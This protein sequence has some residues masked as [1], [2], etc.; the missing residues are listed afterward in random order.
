MLVSVGVMMMVG[1]W[2]S[3]TRGWSL[4]RS[5]MRWQ[6]RGQLSRRFGHENVFPVHSTPASGSLVQDMPVVLLSGVANGKLGNIADR[7][8]QISRSHIAEIQWVEWCSDAQ[9][10]SRRVCEDPVAFMTSH[11][12]R[13]VALISDLA[14]RD[15]EW[16]SS[17]L[18]SPDTFL[19]VSQL[20]GCTGDLLED[21]LKGNLA[22]YA[23]REQNYA[24]FMQWLKEHHRNFINQFQDECRSLNEFRPVPE[25]FTEAGYNDDLH[26][27]FGSHLQALAP[28]WSMPP[29]PPDRQELPLILQDIDGCIK[30]SYCTTEPKYNQFVVDRLN[31]WSRKRTAEVRWMTYWGRRAATV[32]GPTVGLDTFEHGRDVYVED[33]D[34]EV[35][36]FRW[37]ERNPERKI[38]WVDDEIHHYLRSFGSKKNSNLPLVDR[39]MQH[40]NLLMVQP[41]CMKGLTTEELKTI[42]IFL[43]G[44]MKAEEVLAQNMRIV[45]NEKK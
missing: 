1:L 35:Q 26:K 14:S 12:K 2:V 18:Q 16:L 38:V 20:H 28:T 40:P 7:V 45:R 8:N 32:F 10:D 43:T 36:V 21:C 23:V 15:Y 37:I 9:F 24:T 11:P 27:T 25:W 33:P 6:P 41:D 42:D 3:K 39:M 4:G 22:P 29:V 17:R 13:R 34:K 19:W 31:Q 5:A 30:R 44:E